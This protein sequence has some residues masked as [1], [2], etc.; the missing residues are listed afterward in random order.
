MSSFPGYIDKE[1][2][3]SLERKMTRSRESINTKEDLWFVLDQF[4]EPQYGLGNINVKN[5]ASF[6]KDLEMNWSKLD[7]NSKDKV[8]NIMVD[9]IFTNPST[10]YNFKKRFMEKMNIDSPKQVVKESFDGKAL[11]PF[12]NTLFVVLLSVVVL[13][14]LFY[15]IDKTVKSNLGTFPKMF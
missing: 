12:E 6:M 5:C 15:F 7:S 8:L 4:I 2:D 10:D 11:N 9:Y 14:I 3:F 1:D 13:G